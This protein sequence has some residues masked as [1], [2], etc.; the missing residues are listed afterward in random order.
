MAV[1][2]SWFLNPIIGSQ[3]ALVSLV[4]SMHMRGLTY[5]MSSEGALSPNTR[6][7]LKSWA[8]LIGT[9]PVGARSDLHLVV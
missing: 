4:C 1:G 5:W 9:D 6:A 3:S 2:G 8:G 7:A